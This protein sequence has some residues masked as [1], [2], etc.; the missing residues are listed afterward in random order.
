M[1]ISQ[2]LHADDPQVHVEYEIG[3]R[4]GGDVT[5]TPT[6][7]A[8]GTAVP[9]SWVSDAAP[10][11]TLRVEL[12]GLTAGGYRLRAINPDGNDVDLGTVSIDP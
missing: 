4:D 6:C 3:S 9:C 2:W 8:N 1:T 10:N 11:R 5:F 7:T 12:A